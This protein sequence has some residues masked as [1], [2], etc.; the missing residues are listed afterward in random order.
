MPVSKRR[1]TTGHTGLDMA[2]QITSMSA[3]LSQLIPIPALSIATSTVLAIIDVVAEVKTNKTEC[4]R[5]A[6]R[7]SQ[8]LLQLARQME[9]KWDTAPSALVGN[10]QDFEQTLTVIREFMATASD[11]SW[12]KRL[13]G[14]STIEDNMRDMNIRLDAAAQS[15]QIASLIEIHHALGGAVE[16]SSSF[17]ASVAT[18]PSMP[19]PEPAISSSLV[20]VEKEG[21]K[22]KSLEDAI[23]VNVRSRADVEVVE[24]LEGINGSKDKHGFS[25]YHQQDV[26]IGRAHRRGVGWFS[27]TADAQVNGQEITVKRYGASKQDVHRW[28]QDIKLLRQLFHANIPQLVGYS[29][30]QTSV[31]FI[32]L[33]TGATKDVGL[34]AQN[35]LKNESLAR[36]ATAFLDIYRDILSAAL[37]VQQQLSITDEA[38]QDFVEGATYTVDNDNKVLMG[39][40]PPKDGWHT[41][42]SYNLC[43]SL[44]D[45]ALKYLKN[46]SAMEQSSTAGSLA[47]TATIGRTRQL[48][49]LLEALLPSRADAPQLSQDLEDLLDDGDAE[50]GDL[51]RLA[52]ASGRHE[53]SWCERCP[54]GAAA[55]GDYGVL[56]D[57]GKSFES[58]HVFGNIFEDGSGH[59]LQRVK[60]VDGEVVRWESGR[61]HR[62]Q[63]RPYLLPDE[64]EGWPIALMPQGKATVFTSRREN[65]T[66]GSEAWRYFLKHAPAIAQ[67]HGVAVHSILLI[68]RT[69]S[70]NDFQVTDWSAPPLPRPGMSNAI[71]HHHSPQAPYFGARTTHGFGHQ[72]GTPIPTP[73][74][75]YLFTS[76]KQDAVPYL[77]DDP[78][79]RPRPQP[80]RS[81][82]WCF[83]CSSG[84]LV[85]YVNYIQLDPEDLVL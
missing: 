15:F 12:L 17:A 47:R 24:F 26:R 84:W 5:L 32:L 38:L 31:P 18:P 29:D 57:D 27:E 20:I 78:M 35:L 14:K 59:V 55:L 40:A 80:T 61:P 82:S 10:I 42:R 77:T 83:S 25:I 71:V 72:F 68:T 63:A 33:S 34:Y 74:I 9:G 48:M 36:C 79:G 44:V 66:C 60:E 62:E 6:W 23:C 75:V 39:L 1:T 65:L 28:V 21:D 43:E 69:R 52:L 11:A 51:R 58:F 16:S 50:L 53:H 13:V 81:T 70:V 85:H 7:A 56:A 54:A 49:A 3:T 19:L 30:G 4:A 37:H 2:I 41:F 76:G 22:S 73:N 8:M 46:L 67:R 64:L 45:R